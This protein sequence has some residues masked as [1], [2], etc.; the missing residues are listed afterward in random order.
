METRRPGSTCTRCDSMVPVLRGRR[1]PCGVRSQQGG[2]RAEKGTAGQ[3][4]AL[5]GS[6]GILEAWH[7][8]LLTWYNEPKEVCSFLYAYSVLILKII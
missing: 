2:P 8:L 4:R 6:A 7:L 1:G 3:G 5:Q